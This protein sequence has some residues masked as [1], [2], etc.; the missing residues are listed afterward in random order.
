MPDPGERDTAQ[1]V[2]DRFGLTSTPWGER[3]VG[4]A[5]F[6][7]LLLAM[8]HEIDEVRQIGIPAFLLVSEGLRLCEPLESCFFHCAHCGNGERS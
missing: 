3:A 1:P 6:G 8:A 7:I 5:V 2:G 4:K